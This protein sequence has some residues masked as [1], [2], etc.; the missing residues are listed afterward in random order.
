MLKNVT[1]YITVFFFGIISCKKDDTTNSI[2][3]TT[4]T[5]TVG[6]F[7]MDGSGNYVATGNELIFDSHQECQTWSRT[8][9]ADAHSTTTHLHYNAAA[10]VSF[11][12]S[13]TTFNYTE[14]GPELDQ[15]AIETTCEA[16]VNGVDKSVDN[17]S[18][19]QDKPNIYLKITSVVE[20]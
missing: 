15:A 10:N 3:S 14:Y 8:A 4:Y 20:N 17:A 16:G 9:P 7:T 12:Y 1:I 19:Y 2:N 6:A 13:T 11:D 18:Y 5:I